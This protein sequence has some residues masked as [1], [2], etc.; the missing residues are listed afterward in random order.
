MK[1]FE[2]MTSE[3]GFGKEGPFACDRVKYLDSHGG[4]G[5]ELICVESCGESMITA[6][7]IH[8]YRFYW[9]REIPATN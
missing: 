2:Y 1:R 4:D 3:K 9:K 7:V 8:H 5:W 6:G